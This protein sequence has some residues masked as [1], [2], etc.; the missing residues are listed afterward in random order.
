MPSVLILQLTAA[1]P[2]SYLQS[3]GAF[4]HG[5]WFQNWRTY[6]PCMADEMHLLNQVAPFTLSPLIGL[7]PYH[8][9]CQPVEMGDSARLRL[10]SL[11]PELDERLPEWLKSIPPLITLGDINWNIV[12][13][14]INRDTHPLS[15]MTSYDEL[16]LKLSDMHPPEMWE[17]ELQTPTYFNG[18]LWQFPFPL[19]ELMMKSWL[20]RW[21]HF[22]PIA[23]PEQIIAAARDNLVVSRYELRTQTWLQAG[24]R[25]VGC[26]GTLRLKALDLHPSL[27]VAL[28]LLFHYA[29]FSGTGHHTTQGFG[30]TRLM[31]K[32]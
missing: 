14:H 1:Q 3:T 27:R 28:N 10:T 5:W 15:C 24:E 11:S 20:M 25:K 30:Q 4:V 18:K 16:V 19:P 9:G 26:I 22:A 12:G 13:A 32:T 29:E 6:N 21:N 7:R 8:N 23:L 17:I 2:G 31:K